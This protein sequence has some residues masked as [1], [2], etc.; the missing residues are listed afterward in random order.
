V[1]VVVDAFKELS[2]FKPV[3]G[4]GSGRLDEGFF[5]FFFLFGEAALSGDR[6]GSCVEGGGD[7]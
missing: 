7:R 1:K 3:V 2:R 4:S 5:F 6:G